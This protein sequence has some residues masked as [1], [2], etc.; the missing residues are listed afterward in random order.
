MRFVACW[1]SFTS[2]WK[3]RVKIKLRSDAF[4][5][6]LNLRS[7]VPI[8]FGLPAAKLKGM[9]FH[10]RQNSM[11]HFTFYF[12]HFILQLSFDIWPHLSLH[13]CHLTFLVQH[14]TFRFLSNICCLTSE[15]TLRSSNFPRATFEFL[16]CTFTLSY[17]IFKFTLKFSG[18]YFQVFAFNIWAFGYQVLAFNIW[19]SSISLT[20]LHCTFNF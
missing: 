8:F 14:C 12:S 11:L 17:A 16:P 10:P 9:A 1:F 3:D 13:F 15:F 2:R 5:K 6:F 7:G 20:S 4:L 19:L 18:L